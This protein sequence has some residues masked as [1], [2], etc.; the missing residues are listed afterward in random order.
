MIHLL[1]R[2]YYIYPEIQKPLIKFVVI[3]VIS[4]SAL[5]SA[6]IFFSMR[7]LEKV[8]QVDISVVVD[9]R[10]LGPWRNLLYIS[11]F[12]PMV[13]NIILGFFFLLFVSNRF[14]GPL[15]RLERELDRFL[16][17]EKKALN[18]QFRDRDYLHSL[19]KKINDLRVTNTGSMT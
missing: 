13:M 11:V 8:T 16:S 6:F 18:I 12:I 4:V 19:A 2:K 1:R 14:A 17:G 7:W 15:F 10:F 3:S 9:Y 5:Q